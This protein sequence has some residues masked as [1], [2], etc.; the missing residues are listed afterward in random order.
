MYPCYELAIRQN[1]FSKRV[2][3]NNSFVLLQLQHVYL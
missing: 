1:E 2:V 3:R